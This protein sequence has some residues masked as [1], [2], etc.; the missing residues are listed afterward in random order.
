MTKLS[1]NMDQMYI[2]TKN[3]FSIVFSLIT[4]A[5]LEVTITSAPFFLSFLIVQLN[6]VCLAFPIVQLPFLNM[7]LNF[8]SFYYLV[9]LFF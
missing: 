7:A 9:N 3:L 5:S 8:I 2:L 1:E 6:G 4:R